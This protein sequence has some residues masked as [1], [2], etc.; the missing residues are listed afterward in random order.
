[1]REGNASA[2]RSTVASCGEELR[3]PAS[4]SGEGVTDESVFSDDSF[5]GVRSVNSGLVAWQKLAQ[6][7]CCLATQLCGRGCGQHCRCGRMVVISWQS[8]WS[9][10][11]VGGC[12]PRIIALKCRHCIHT[13]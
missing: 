13:R 5:L 4:E 1:M 12:H 7:T 3:W 9:H 6:L 10:R 8:V 2:G 11:R